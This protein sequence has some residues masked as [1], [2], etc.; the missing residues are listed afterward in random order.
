MIIRMSSTI[1]AGFIHQNA[2]TAYLD[3]Q[4]GSSISD[5]KIFESLP[6]RMEEEFH[7]DMRALNVEHRIYASALFVERKAK[8]ALFTRFSMR[9]N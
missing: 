5:Y 7:G 1:Y 8:S 4:Q 3:E 6:R 2:V 9:T